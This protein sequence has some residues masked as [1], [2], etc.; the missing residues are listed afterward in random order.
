MSR[1]EQGCK[2]DDDLQTKVK[3][4]VMVMAAVTSRLSE[5]EEEIYHLRRAMELDIHSRYAAGMTMTSTHIM[6][7]V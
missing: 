7:Q 2:V 3:D 4:Q 5:E 6:L 1:A